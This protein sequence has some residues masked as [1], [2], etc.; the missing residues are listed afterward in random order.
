[1]TKTLSHIA[2]GVE[3]FAPK[4]AFIGG[5]TAL[6]MMVAVVREVV[7]RYLFNSPS[8]WSLEL[9]E[10]LVVVMVFL[11]AA[12]VTLINA[13]IKADMLYAR[14]SAK[15][16]AIADIMISLMALTYVVMLT[17]Q[18]ILYSHELL[19]KWSRSSG[20]MMWPLFP[21]QATI[22]IGGVLT[23]LILLVVL[24][25]SITLLSGRRG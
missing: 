2:R 21:S 6:I 17:Y 12:W 16:K 18:S 19:V 7:G 13:H 4:I 11:G 3:W 23:S 25:R 14:F 9:C 10:N 5:I 15:K 1:M 24:F 8:D 20:M 22:S